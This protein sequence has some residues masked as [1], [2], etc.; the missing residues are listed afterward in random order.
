ML[1]REP[2]IKQRARQWIMEWW[3]DGRGEAVGIAG[4]WHRF[5]ASM[6]VGGS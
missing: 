6:A 5:A 1:C 2:L 4:S 3:A